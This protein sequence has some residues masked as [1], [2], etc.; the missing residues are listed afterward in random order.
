M[1]G[2]SETL[3]DAYEK[4]DNVGTPDSLR[5]GVKESP[6]GAPPRTTPLMELLAD[7]N[8]NNSWLKDY[9]VPQMKQE[10]INFQT[11]FESGK[12]PSWL[13]KVQELGK[14]PET[15]MDIARFDKDRAQEIYN[16]SSPER[17]E[18]IH[19]EAE[20][21]YMAL[22]KITNAIDPSKMKDGAVLKDHLTR[23]IENV[24]GFME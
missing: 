23:M 7:P 1:A 8:K 14:S 2:R 6:A 18:A 21:T 4:V 17:K 16:T 11:G 5:G 3:V 24:K 9:A 22:M 10:I 12:G 20:K 15:F 13:A 19:A